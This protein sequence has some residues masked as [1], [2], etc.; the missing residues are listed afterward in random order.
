ML[1]PQKSCESWVGMQQIKAKMLQST[2]FSRPSTATEDY[3]A[4]L[5]SDPSSTLGSPIPLSAT[6][7]E[8]ACRLIPAVSLHRQLR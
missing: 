7:T 3:R 6:A 8:H 1:E 5:L 4:W 2:S